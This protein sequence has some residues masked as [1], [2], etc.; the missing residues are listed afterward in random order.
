MD[1]T[2][3]DDALR[4]AAAARR[5]S[6]SDL[7][8]WCFGLHS[9]PAFSGRRDSKRRRAGILGPDAAAKATQG[10]L[11]SVFSQAHPAGAGRLQRDSESSAVRAIRAC[12][13]LSTRPINEGGLGPYFLAEI[14]RRANVEAVGAPISVPVSFHVMATL[15]MKECNDPSATCSICLKHLSGEALTL[16]CAHY[17]HKKCIMPWLQIHNSCPCCRGR[18]ASDLPAISPRPVQTSVER[19]R[20]RSERGKVSAR[21]LAL[22]M[23]QWDGMTGSTIAALA[24]PAASLAGG[25]EQLTRKRVRASVSEAGY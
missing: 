9:T 25:V 21:E 18:V 13:N 20:S 11:S 16:P 4:V 7:D 2:F 1:S 6:A 10:G 24:V 17:F 8:T 23:R 5:K 22:R 12:R 19:Q 14:F 3:S 15:P